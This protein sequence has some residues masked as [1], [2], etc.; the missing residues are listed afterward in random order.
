MQ[1]FRICRIP[2]LLIFT[3]CVVCLNACVHLRSP[4][5]SGCIEH[6]TAFDIG[7]ET[8]KMKVAK[9]DQCEGKIVKVVCRKEIKVS[10]ADNIQNKAFTAHV[11]DRG[12]VAIQALKREAKECGS[13]KFSGA[14]TAAFRNAT[15]A[16]H[17]L[18]R[19]KKVTG[20]HV[21]LVSQDEEAI[22]GY[23]AA[24]SALGQVEK[25]LVVWDIGG[26]SMQ[27]TMEDDQGDFIIYRGSLASV[28]FKR[29]IINDLQHQSPKIIAS[30]NPIG[31]KNLDAALE[32]A[33][34]A[35]EEVPDEIK[36]KV[37]KKETI[38]AGIGGVHNAS[39]RQQL[40]SKNIYKR[41]DIL[42]VLDFR[43]TLTDREI[44]GN[45]AQTE[46]SNLILVLGYMNKLDINA[47]RLLDVNLTDGILIDPD[48]W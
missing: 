33:M 48:F 38:I 1:Y 11:Q 4:L 41:D 31:R 21:E 39:V 32:I 47:V 28:S 23:L 15:N 7:S 12:I 36:I 10:Y 30:P 35:A 43:L 26:S 5:E 24:V 6:R 8:T 14:A 42:A 20:V 40:Q 45:Y 25:K 18:E 2:L 19:I 29:K 17:F 34:Q 13:E 44:G 16:D 22:L 27:I 37:G 46:V 3:L 9:V